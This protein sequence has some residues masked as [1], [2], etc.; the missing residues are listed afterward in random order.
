MLTVLESAEN[1]SEFL[2]C[3]LNWYV[4]PCVKLVTVKEVAVI[5]DYITVNVDPD[6]PFER[7]L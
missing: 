7:I 5:S 6:P 2:A 4:V 3:T 1:P